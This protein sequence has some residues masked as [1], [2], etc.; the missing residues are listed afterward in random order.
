MTTKTTLI[1]ALFT[2]IITFVP[3]AKAGG[4]SDV[5]IIMQILASQQASGEVV[6]LE[7]RDGDDRIG[8]AEALYMLQDCMQSTIQANAGIDQSVVPGTLVQLDGS[9][10][11][12]TS[13]MISQYEWTLALKPQGS[14]AVLSNYALL[15]PTFS[16]DV[17]GTYTVQLIVYDGD[18][19]SPP[20]TIDII[21]ADS[22]ATADAGPDQNIKTGE[23]VALDGS[24]SSSSFGVILSSQW[25]IVSKPSGSIAALSDE[26]VI[27]PTF[28][29]DVDGIY[30]IALVVDDGLAKSP[31]DTVTI[32]AASLPPAAVSTIL[33]TS[34]KDNDFELY[35]MHADGTNITQLTSNTVKDSRGR[36][37][38]DHQKI[39]FIRNDTAVWIMN[40]DGTNQQFIHN[41]KTVDFSSDGLK[42]IFSDY[43]GL[44]TGGG[45]AL[46]TYDLQ[47]NQKIKIIDIGGKDFNPDCFSNKI[48]F[49]NYI[50][51]GTVSFNN[52]YSVN[53]NG[54]GKNKLTNYDDWDKAFPD[55][56]RWS[57]DGTRILY[58]Y[59]T[60]KSGKATLRIMNAD[61]SN[62]RSLAEHAT[63]SL[64]SPVWSPDGTQAVSSLNG[65]LIK[66]D[67]EDVAHAYWLN[68]N[69]GHFYYPLDWAAIEQE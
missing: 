16:A 60:S 35:T 44:G 55:A 37:S 3:P 19:A 2:V 59:Q 12:N 43:G 36:W 6:Q 57:R 48:V 26:G 18:I 58:Q 21:A 63:S 41:G 5:I 9:G 25:S 47:T 8:M 53:L 54:S 17:A 31:A 1:T 4:L 27:N 65:R 50:L 61:G 14:D 11:T 52:L 20:D 39:A 49:T 33:F 34:D 13:G 68:S 42:L 32:T 56:S 28:I 51:N 69:D 10:S 62:K 67:I 30:V 45:D 29:A 22:F 7:D 46:F 64:L 15:N 23:T 38:P 24:A 40:S 66:F